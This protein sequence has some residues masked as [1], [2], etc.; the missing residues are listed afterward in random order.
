MSPVIKS[1]GHTTASTP[2]PHILYRFEVDNDGEVSV[3]KKRY[4]EVS[5]LRMAGIAASV[6]Q[7]SRQFAALHTALGKPDNVQLPP[8][9][10]LATTF[11]PSAWVD[12]TLIAERKDGLKAYLN[13]VLGDD[14]I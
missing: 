13:T 14:S 2:R 8:K 1:V 7:L 3:V 5:Y 4:S 11:I 9:R 6:L 10:I 12:D